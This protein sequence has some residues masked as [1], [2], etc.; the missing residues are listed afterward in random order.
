MHG[1]AGLRVS[2]CLRRT[3]TLVV[4]LHAA[5]AMCGL[6][7]METKPMADQGRGRQH[8]AKGWRHPHAT[9]SAR[10]YVRSWACCIRVMFCVPWGLFQSAT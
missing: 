6:H 10:G 8:T 3:G 4:A 9:C 5:Q 1:C 7:P 2:C